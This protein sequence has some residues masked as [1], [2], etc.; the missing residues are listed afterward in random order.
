MDRRPHGLCIY[1]SNRL[2][3]LAEA[4]GQHLSEPLDHPLASECILVP[5]R[6]VAQWLSLELSQRFG[7]WANVLY[8]YPRDFVGWALERVLGQP[9]GELQ[10]L[11]PE[12]LLWSICGS[13][14]PLL[15]RPEFETIRRYVT[16]V[17]GDVRYFELCRRIATTFD[18]YAAYRPDLLRTWERKPRP[19]A[20][21]PQLDLFGVPDQTRDWQA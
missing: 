19:G 5:G 18:H 3:R 8:L 7:V 16:G 17:A 15:D 1:R 14:R 20:E 21:L 11:D 13:L 12:R 9:A 6:G 4:L 2:E 10:A